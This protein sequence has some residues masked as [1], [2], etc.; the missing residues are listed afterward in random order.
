LSSM[1][2]WFEPHKVISLV[3]EGEATRIWLAIQKV[4][5]MLVDEE[6]SQI[7][8]IN[9]RRALVVFDGNRGESLRPEARA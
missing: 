9:P 5:I 3:P 1:H 2:A 6:P 4:K 8:L 7:D